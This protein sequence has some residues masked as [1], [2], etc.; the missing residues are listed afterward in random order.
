MK[1]L[2]S[3][4]RGRHSK[5]SSPIENEEFR[6][7]LRQHVKDNARDKGKVLTLLQI[8]QWVGERLELD[9]SH[10]YSEPTVMR[11][12]HLMGFKIQTVKKSLYVDGHEREDVVAARNKFMVDYNELRKSRCFQGG[13]YDQADDVQSF[14][15]GLKNLWLVMNLRH[16]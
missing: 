16:H 11:W 15:G 5:T 9:E 4:H 6:Q 13:F 12:L 2:G 10:W 3:D 7:D 1:R 14:Q 8:R